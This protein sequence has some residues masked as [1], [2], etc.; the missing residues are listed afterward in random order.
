MET[1]N[2]LPN[3]NRH[4]DSRDSNSQYYSDNNERGRG[5]ARQG[6][7]YDLNDQGSHSSRVSHSSRASHLQNHYNDQGIHSSQA[8]HLQNHYNDEAIQSVHPSTIHPPSIHPIMQAPVLV[9]NTNAERDQ[10]SRA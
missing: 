5:A 7:Q 1:A 10:G 9:L 8:S 3:D 2:K 4:Y 6:Y